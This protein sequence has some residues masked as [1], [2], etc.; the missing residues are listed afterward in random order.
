MTM[1]K[2]IACSYGGKNQITQEFFYYFLQ[3]ISSV[4]GQKSKL[5]ITN[6]TKTAII[7][8]YDLILKYFFIDLHI[9][10][11]QQSNKILYQQKRIAIQEMFTKKEDNYKKLQKTIDTQLDSSQISLMVTL[12]LQQ[13]QLQLV[14]W[15]RLFRHMSLLCNTI[16]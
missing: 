1:L 9:T 5:T 6:E 8:E 3:Y 14:I 4:E 12:I 7:I 11:L 10:V 16:L 15:S 13:L 2:D